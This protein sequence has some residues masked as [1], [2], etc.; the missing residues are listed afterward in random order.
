M[1][2][3]RSISRG[4]KASLTVKAILRLDLL[5]R[6]P[7]SDRCRGTDSPC[8]AGEHRVA[9]E[10]SDA[11]SVSRSA[12]GFSPLMALFMGLTMVFPIAIGFGSPRDVAR[13]ESETWSEGGR[14]TTVVDW[15]ASLPGTPGRSGGSAS[16][17]RVCE[18]EGREIDCDPP[19]G[20]S[21]SPSR[22]CFVMPGPTSL[23]KPDGAESGQ[24]YRCVGFFVVASW[25]FWAETPP[26]TGLPP[27]ELAGQAVASLQ[28]KPIRIGMTPT[29]GGEGLVGLPTWLW[30]AGPSAQTWGPASTRASSGP[31]S[32]S[33]SAEV[34]KVVWHMGDGGVVVCR[35]AGTKYR[36]RFGGEPSPNCGYDYRTSSEDEPGGRFRIRAVSHWVVTWQETSGGGQSGELR[37]Q[38]E[39]TTEQSV[40][41]LQVLI[42]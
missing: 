2:N 10:R 20:G 23:P 25:L 16:V 35:N 3:Q 41:E 19:W 30:V 18:Y 1:L 34:E 14:V 33:L 7:E 4:L 42:R 32:V 21:W 38:L 22:R 12:R 28:L 8:G 15:N 39:S 40:R 26:Q 6:D 27:S 29:R 17:Q 31:V 11:G 5:Q 24:W 9:S 37:L 36:K 13:A